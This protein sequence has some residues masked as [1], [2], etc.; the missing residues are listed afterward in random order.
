MSSK[1]KKTPYLTKRALSFKYAFKGIFTAI[2][3]QANLRIHLFAA[4][5]VTAMGFYFQISRAEWILVILAIGVVISAELFNS[6]IEF[7]TDLVSP[8][9]NETAGKVKDI[10]AG[11]VLI[12]AIS[13]AIIGLIIFLPK[14]KDLF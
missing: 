9:Q 6:A 2:K 5:L 1:N 7:L 12:S 14:I 11:A 3:T 8:G 13:A 4:I 10:A